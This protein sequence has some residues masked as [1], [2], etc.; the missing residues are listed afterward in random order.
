MRYLLVTPELTHERSRRR[1]RSAREPT[2]VEA[3]LGPIVL[4]AALRPMS[5]AILIGLLAIVAGLLALYAVT[6]GVI[7]VGRS[8]ALRLAGRG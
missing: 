7:V 2:A 3:V 8:L 4:V 5:S 1:E 6:I